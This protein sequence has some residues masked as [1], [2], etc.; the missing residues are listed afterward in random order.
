M[1]LFIEGFAIVS[2]N[3]MVADESGVMPPSLI[4]TADQEFLSQALDRAVIIVHGRNSHERQA[5]S[6]LRRRLIAT[7]SVKT[8]APTSD[9]PLARLWNPDGASLA[10]AAAELGVKEGTAA[11]LGG[12]RLYEAFLPLYDVFNL[13]RITTLDIPDGRPVF[14]L[15]PNESPEHH[16]IQSGLC[17]E[18]YRVIDAPRG[19]TMTTWRRQFG[20]NRPTSP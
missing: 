5:N 11:I 9:Y 8:T 10:D 12:T 6:A 17:A 7:N 1:A 16:L 2:N 19:V 13:S 14:P 18:K 3:G 4:I 20:I 15:A